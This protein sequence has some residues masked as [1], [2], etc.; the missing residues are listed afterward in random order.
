MRR[1]I[2]AGIVVLLLAGALAWWYVGT[3]EP[4][5][6]PRP[7]APT[8]SID[9]AAASDTLRQLEAALLAGDRDAA[10]GLGADEAT[11]ELL[12]A[13][14]AN[15]AELRLDDLGLRYLSETDAPMG[16]GSWSAEVELVWRF[17]GFDGQ[18][19]AR[20]PVEFGFAESGE[21]IAAV[22]GPDGLT[23][24]WLQGRVSTERGG[25]ALVIALNEERV[26]T[27]H[28]QAR[29]AAAVVRGTFGGQ[30]RLVVEVPD[31]ID[32]LHRAIGAE[33]GSYDTIAAVTTGAD[34]HVVPGTPLHVFV[35]PVVYDD[36]DAVA[37]QV[38]MTHEAVHVVTEAPF[39]RAVPLWLLEGFADFI[40]LR[41]VD[42]P[43]ARTA[44][45]VIEQVRTDG[46]PDHLPDQVDFRVHEGHLGAAY[47][48]AWVVCLV[49][50]EA[51]G[52]AELI[53]MYEAVVAGSDL[54]AELQQRF[55][56]SEADLLAAWQER[57]RE[58]AGVR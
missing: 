56:W 38:V 49:L 40:A 33:R 41:E 19:A 29:E 1:A 30:H 24:L 51:G 37:A 23:P 4:Y 57:L 44:A 22:G 36:L 32:G 10:A 34:G 46:V 18:S 45:Q 17:G 16:A 58:L 43:M 39:G 14:A 55:G 42:L 25:G 52:D 50:A 20:A 13:A 47:E 12:A 2:G 26:A 5:V 53:A 8:D 6:A 3:D 28:R 21:S 7:A 48:A 31:S 27:Y 15:A 35:N 11:A 54:A 9:A